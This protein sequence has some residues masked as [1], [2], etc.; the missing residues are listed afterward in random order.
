M[1]RKKTGEENVPFLTAVMEGKYLDS[2]IEKAGANAP[3][4]MN[5]DMQAI[6]GAVDFVGLNLY[7]GQYVRADDAA[8]G[9]KVLPQS[10][11][12]PQMT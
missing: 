4:V 11:S 10:A 6:A 8:S 5:G 3:V 1:L 9:Y 12:T 2:Y 7:T